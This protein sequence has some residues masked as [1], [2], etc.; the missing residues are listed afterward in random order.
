MIMKKTAL[1][2]L[3][4]LCT[5]TLECQP[6][7][8]TVANYETPATPTDWNFERIIVD[9]TFTRGYQVTAADFNNDQKP[10]LAAVSDREKEIIWYENPSWGKHIISNTTT[11]NID[12]A[13]H[14]VNADGHIDLA[15]A[16]RFALN[17]SEEGGYIYW[18][19]NPGSGGKLWEK[20]YIDSIPTAHRIRWVDM[21]GDGEEELI[22]LPII[23]IGAVAPEY[24]VPLDMVSYKI[25]KDPTAASWPKTII[26]SSL[27]M[28]HGI[29]IEQFNNDNQPDILTASFEG[30]MLFTS[31]GGD[32]NHAWE[33]RQ[34]GSGDTSPRPKQG[35]SEVGLGTLRAANQPFIAT[36][37]PW[38]GHQVVV[39]TPNEDENEL[40][41][42]KIID[43]TFVDGHAL[44]CADLNNDGISE[45]IAGHRGEGYHLYIYQYNAQD[46]EWSRYTLDKGGMS[47]A[48]LF[49]F[50]FDA[51]G[52]LDIAACGS[53][54]N[55]VVLY[56][57]LL[58]K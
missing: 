29:S 57:N 10:D 44:R 52:Y 47:A 6:Q 12:L 3:F 30:V 24:D 49:I 11:Q 45:I 53:R 28:A 16:C 33:K 54:T 9:S 15:L 50:D 13:P 5:L 41:T 18:L 36:I 14:D 39:Y 23:G 34:L 1:Y 19:E 43:T 7:K 46:N 40:W 48:G 4:S 8:N 37:E 42:R 55:N 51:D 35:A 22:N 31:A 20:H 25:P 27:H 21:D 58:G 17:N 56:R 38:H 26:D 2:I 32:G